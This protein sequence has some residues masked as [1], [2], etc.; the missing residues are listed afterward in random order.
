MIFN[1]LFKSKNQ[2]ADDRADAWEI[3][4]KPISD[5]E[6]EQRETMEII[7]DLLTK[8]DEINV[9]IDEMKNEDNKDV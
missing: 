3:L 6:A 7:E 5:R 8:L 9:L 2:K 1:A 4:E